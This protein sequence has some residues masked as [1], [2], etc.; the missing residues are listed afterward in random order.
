MKTIKE[1]MIDFTKDSEYRR[2]YESEPDEKTMERKG[3]STRSEKTNR[4]N[5]EGDRC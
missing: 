5:T 4:Q 1:K 2:M 3:D